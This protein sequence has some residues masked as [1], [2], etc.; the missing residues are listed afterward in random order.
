MPVYHEMNYIS[1]IKFS[2]IENYVEEN[3]L[4]SLLGEIKDFEGKP[5][6][7]SEQIE[8][9]WELLQERYTY[10][11][12]RYTD[13]M[14][15]LLAIRRVSRFA[16]PALIEK[17]RLYGEIYTTS[18]ETLRKERQNLRNMVEKP[19]IVGD[20]NDKV[21]ITDLSTV[22]ETITSITGTIDEITDK[23]RMTNRNYIK[24][25]YDEYNPLFSK[26]ITDT[27][28]VILYP[29]EEH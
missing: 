15:A 28:N 25:F 11:N 14:A 23:W 7:T 20:N 24:E 10:S 8:Y 9:A 17:Q 5:L 21:P 19:N 3:G 29:Q 6:L 13:I 1:L 27:D 22:Q 16:I 2:D 12:M 18:V 26:I 4:E